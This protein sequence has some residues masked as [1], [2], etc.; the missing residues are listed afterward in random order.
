MGMRDRHYPWP[1]KPQARCPRVVSDAG[2][3]I[4]RK[5]KFLAPTGFRYAESLIRSLA[6]I[7]TKNILAPHIWLLEPRMW[8]LDLNNINFILRY[9]HYLTRA[10]KD[11]PFLAR[12]RKDSSLHDGED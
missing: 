8:T 3:D 1:L 10:T 6:S 2:M 11:S 7:L 5:R 9:R 4:L 12:S